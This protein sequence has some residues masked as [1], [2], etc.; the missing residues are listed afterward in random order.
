MYME[1]LSNGSADLTQSAI[2]DGAFLFKKCPGGEIGRRKGLKIPRM[3][4]PC[5]FDSGPGH[6]LL[7]ISMGECYSNLMIKP[8]S[9][10]IGLRYTRAKRRNHFISFIA[11]ASMLGI[12][13]GVT[14]LITVLLV[15]NGFDYQIRSKF[16]SIAPQV[17]VLTSESILSEWRSLVKKAKTIPGVLNAAPYVSGKGMILSSGLSVSPV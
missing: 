1:Y 4:N 3:N 8:L 17:T 12:A 14:V 16:F 10:F 2:K 11:L 9:L 7:R 15:M 5:R 6:H 13:L